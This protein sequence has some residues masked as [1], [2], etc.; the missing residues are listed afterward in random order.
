MLMNGNLEIFQICIEALGCKK[1]YFI[2]KI[3]EIN[4]TMIEKCQQMLASQQ[5][6]EAQNNTNGKFST[7]F[8][9]I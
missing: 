8:L 9:K 5:R 7:Q 4:T 2:Y 6:P 3:F 1:I